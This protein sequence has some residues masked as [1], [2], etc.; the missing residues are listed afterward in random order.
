ME[1]NVGKEVAV[2]RR[3]AEGDLTERLRRRAEVRLRL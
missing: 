3:M 1:L 2:L